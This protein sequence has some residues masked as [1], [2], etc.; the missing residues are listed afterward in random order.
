M[1]DEPDILNEKQQKF[2][3]LVASGL[4]AQQA[5]RQ[6]GWSAS[7][8][9]KAS[10]LLKNPSIRQAIDAIQAEART[11]AVYGVVEAMREAGKAMQFATQHKNA[12]AYVKAVELRAKLSGLLI[13]RVELVTVDL[14]GAIERAQHRVLSGLVTLKVTGQDN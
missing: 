8:A 5:A 14:S 9:R 11:V 4:S 3:S 1:S 2:V 6:V 7:Y 13:D 10:G 12:N